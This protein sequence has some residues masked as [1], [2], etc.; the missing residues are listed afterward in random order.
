M[1]IWI[2][3]DVA[4]RRLLNRVIEESLEKLVRGRINTPGAG[5]P[6]PDGTAGGQK[7]ISSF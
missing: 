3:T 2:Q 7:A 5:G 6:T 4:N 1:E